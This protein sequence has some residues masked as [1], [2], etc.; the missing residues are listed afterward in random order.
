MKD[1]WMFKQCLLISLLCASAASAEVRFHSLFGDH[2]VLQQGAKTPV[3]GQA[4]AGEAVELSIAGQTGR[5]IADNQGTWR[6]DLADLKAGGPYELVAKGTNT[7]AL[8]DVYIGDVW[9][10]SGQSNMDFTVGKTKQ[11]S[12]AGVNDEAAE[13]AA[14]D[15]PL[16]RA[17]TLELNLA[18]TPQ[19]QIVGTWRVCSPATVP[20]ISAVAYF[21]ARELRR[22]HD[23]PVGLIISSYGASTAQ[24]WISEESLRS[25]P[26]LA[27]MLPAYAQSV[28]DYNSGAAQTKYE[29]ALKD[30]EAASAKAKAD[31]KPAPRKPGA[32]KDPSKDQHNPRLLYNGMIAPLRPAAFRGVI[33]YQGESNGY[34]NELY[35]SLMTTLIADWRGKFDRDFPFLFVQLANYKSPAT[36]PVGRSQIAQV[37]EAQRL[38]L[39]VPNTAMVVTLD[40]GDAKDVH[41]RNKQDVG[42]RL[43]TAA[44]AVVYGEKV[45]YSGPLF[46]SARVEGDSIRVKFEHADGLRISKGDALEGF[47]I[48]TGD[49]WS[50]ADARIDGGDVLVSVPGGKAVSELRYAWAD[51]PPNN[52]TNST[53]FPASSFRVELPQP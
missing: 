8:R 26:D 45:A 6:I 35:L 19:S 10:C 42:L 33:W 43:A 39:A 29:Q 27:P 49:E 7:V 51:N 2:M 3:W 24:T 12:F 14:A 47:A 1:G 48:R 37:R 16:I 28:A 17:V 52:L 22:H 13:V 25:K 44:R 41:P 30:W 9:L 53:G 38:T 18:E 20:D 36:Q 46:A 31:G 11:R 21:F 5:T 23:V 40:I 32:P 15:H 34:N 4:D 50:W